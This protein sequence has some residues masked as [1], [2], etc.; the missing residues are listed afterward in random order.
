MSSTHR[1]P[2]A[3]LL[4]ALCAPAA[5]ADT[6]TA[7]GDHPGEGGTPFT[8]LAQ[9]P[10]ANLFTGAL[11]TGVPI[12]VP[13]GRSGMTPQL[14]LQHVSGGGPSPFGHG[15]DLTLG[16]IER[17]SRW[18]TPRCSGGH[19]DEFVLVL[20]SGAAELVR[21]TPSSRYY[22]PRV[23]QAWVRA[24]RI[25]A[26]N[27]WQVVDR[28]GR[29]YSFGDVDAAR[30]GNSDPLTFLKQEADGSCRLTSV[31]ALT[32]VADPNGNAIDIAWSKI[33]N[34][35]YPATVRW[36][37]N[38]A[39]G[40]SHF[41][42]VRFLPEWRP[43]T[44]R[45]ASA[46]LGVSARLAWRIYGIDVETDLPSAGTI[47]RSYALQYRDGDGSGADGY[48]SMLAAVGVT[49]RPTQH[50]VYTP[51]VTGHDAISQPFA[52]PAIAYERLRETNDS[53]E[54]SQSVLDMNGDG[55][56]DLVRSN[57]A[58]AASWAVF[59]GR[60]G[61]DGSF[62]FD[63][64][65][66]AWQAP[67]NWTHLR[68]VD[69]ASGACN[70]NGWQC[71]RL[72][73]F[74]LTGDGIPDFVD[75][76]SASS[77]TVY[78]G[79]G[80]PQWGFGPGIAWP[81]PNLRYVRRS[82]FGD[83][84]QDVVDVN[85][86]GLADLVRSGAP[87]QTAPFQ[88]QVYL[89]TGSGFATTALPRFPA[90][91]GTL[92][93][94]VAG[95]IGHELVDFNGDGLP[96]LVRSG[97]AGGFL[98]D[99]RCQP[100]S[101]ALTSCLEV[102]LNRGDGF[103]ELEAPIPVPMSN[104]VQTATDDEEVYQDLFDVNGDGLP[105]WLY[106][107]YDFTLGNFQPEW[108]VL[109]NLG[110]TLEPVTYVP[111]TVSPLY[112]EAIPPRVWPGGAGFFRRSSDGQSVVDLVD[113]NGDGLLDQL[114]TGGPTWFV[115]LHAAAEH[116]NLLGLLENGLGGTTTVVYR[117][118]TAFDNSGGDAQPDLPFIQ[119]V[120]AR[121]RQ[122][123]GLCTPPASADPFVAGPGPNANPCIDAGHE[124]IA[125]YDYEDGRFDAATR[126]F[127]GF[128]RVARSLHEG[129][130]A[131]A[132]L[133]VSVFA[134]DALVKGRVLSVDTYAGDTA[135]VRNETNLWGTRDAGNGRSQ[136]WLAEQR[137]ATLDGG[138]ASVPLYVTT[139][140]DAPDEY[141]NITHARREGLFGA[142]RVD[143][144]TTYA[145]PQSG[146]LVYD[147]PSGVRVD[148]ASGTLQEEWLYYDGG[149]TNGLAFGKIVQGNLKRRVQRLDAAVANG[150]TTRME[151]DAVGNLTRATDAN[152]RVT[153][154]TYDS[155][156]L[157]PATVT[158]PLG[159]VTTT[160]FDLRVGQP[161]QVTD[162][163]GATTSYA[164]DSAGRR[165]CEAR[166]Y[167]SLATC[168]R[169]TVYHFA[170][171]AG[172]LSWVEH[173]VRQDN[174]PPLWVRQYFDG[175]GRARYSDTLR[176]VDGAPTMVRGN[177]VEYDAA[178]RVA[179][180]RQPH[181][182]GSAA[183]GVTSFDY[184]LNGG[185]A[186]DPLG[187]IHLTTAPDHT[188]R[189]SIYAGPTTSSWDE[190]NQQS[191]TVV[192]GVGRVVER[193]SY[194]DGSVAMR[195]QQS[196]DGLGRL[197]DVRQNGTLLKSFS[198]DALGRKTRM[199]DLD[200]GTWRY[201]YDAV[202]NLLW[203]DDPRAGHHVELCYDAINR[204]TRRCSYPSDFT[205]SAACSAACTDPD[206]VLIQY[207]AASVPFGRGRRTRV[208]DG[209]GTAEVLAYD[210]RGRTLATRRSIELDGV[211]RAARF[212]YAYDTNDRVTAVTYPDGEVV[213]T[214]YDDAGQPIALYNT[215]GT[216]YVTDARYDLRG[217]P[218]RLDH[219]N[220]LSDQRT[221]GGAATQYRLQALRSLGP[222]GT[223]L[224]LTFPAYT[225]RGLL[226]RIAD[227]RN[228]S[229]PLSDTV[230]YDYDALGRLRSADSAHNPLDRSFEY[231]AMGNLARN[232]DVA[233][234]Y[235]NP[236]RPHQVTHVAAP[237]GAATVA[238]DEN[239]N[240]LG[241]PGQ[242]YT[243]DTADQLARVDVG[244]QTVRYLH[245]A[246]G[247]LVGKLVD[248]SP[249]QTA[250]YYDPRLEV[251][252]TRQTKW[253]FL[254]ERRIASMTNGY[255]SWQTAARDP[256][257]TVWLAAAPMSRPALIL[258][259]GG[260]ARWV[261]AALLLGLTT[262]T[263]A[264]RGPR[265]AAGGRRVRRGH[266]VGVALLGAVG[267]LPWPLAVGPAPAWAGGGGG[268]GTSSLP[269]Y[270]FHLDHLGSIQA[271]SDANGYLF[272]Q[273]RYQPF[274]GVSGRFNGSGQPY[275]GSSM[276]APRYFTGYLTDPLAGL[277][278]AGARVYDPELGSFLSHDPGSQ[279][280]S[281]YSYG[282]GDP[283]NW[284][285]PNGEFFFFFLAALFVSAF[286]SAAVSTVIAAAQGLP[287]S[288]VGRAAIGGAIAGAIGVGI[289]V[290]A[291]A[292]SIG[293]AALAGTL[294]QNVTLQQVG[295]ALTGV[296]WRSAYS[297]TLANAAGQTA[298]AVGAPQPVALL[299]SVAA[300]FLSSVQFD[301]AF[302]N[303][304][305]AVA[306][307]VSQRSGGM[308]STTA[309]HTDITSMAAA[310]AGFSDAEA[311]QILAGSL[312]E[313]LNLWGN[314]DHFDFLSQQ[315]A[316]A[317]SRAAML[318]ADPT[319][320]LGA[321]RMFQYTGAALHHVQD[322]YAL[323]HVVP[324]TSAFGGPLG[325]PARFLI[326]N[327]A[328]GEVTFRQASY[329]ASLQLLRDVRAAS[330][331]AG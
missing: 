239:G 80:V 281:P 12:E 138:A 103:G 192:D 266:A 321:Q 39:A 30:L 274:G 226:Q 223:A 275:V 65:P 9:V 172:E 111:S 284:T 324:G 329:D 66:T 149:T 72:D 287:L 331:A 292:T 1:L 273:V 90:P 228:P 123:D 256:G 271:V 88:W 153:V 199:S 181:V 10:E 11:S 8:G 247:V 165:V 166:P 92:V 86:D 76:S 238:H 197:L 159:H 102:Y 246:D 56:L 139:I 75:A 206:P 306:R 231:D 283:V 89:N 230:T 180:I 24:E 224:D 74:D 237:G 61:G 134:Q 117:P 55:L 140:S 83:T 268:G 196:Y 317:N 315:A 250:R 120:V 325:A 270:H 168:S 109:L 77:W 322:P 208:E 276:E 182:A 94:H 298:T 116:P 93:D 155:V 148:D 221:Y 60:V 15:W 173:A 191:D 17:S 48:Q 210:A 282:G 215:A 78:P 201:G 106:R 151:Y 175:L 69:V 220:G 195:V 218:L 244:G 299:A 323:G 14:T 122:N 297:T 95:G 278:H 40:I 25:D 19:T 162:P 178:G 141:G 269:I 132:G 309:T 302:A 79:R 113:V 245:D 73:T 203:Q 301:Q 234:T 280:T 189:R 170:A 176:V 144:T 307:D 101:T 38:P 124:L 108:R 114:T 43:P 31:W 236:S 49:G 99:P 68:N 290:L 330:G 254:G 57:D 169:S 129:S 286:A 300:G 288:A 32:R 105:D 163:N 104:A 67:G 5:R 262:L 87:G 248:G 320:G 316:G 202:G 205:T 219:A 85:G 243:Y 115:R 161:S 251:V 293:A 198:Y 217:R 232:G 152:G 258:A 143:T 310:D 100:S 216:F 84:Y 212:D 326:H 53:L 127:R 45:I 107:R 186:R 157:H 98:Y 82:Y 164:Y 35:L 13:P 188:T 305:G 179:L 20:P 263:F 272:E 190:E 59:W 291:T 137:I 44:D 311:Q 233:L 97:S 146:S 193:R 121:T 213:R 183:D 327:L 264:W 242:L 308:C 135:L 18:G 41:Y 255:L 319:N 214:E 2:L 64:A 174:H 46:R 52:K 227:Q 328:G 130:A 33:F 26:E 312:A 160:A 296:A 36:G 51:S 142:N 222:R 91:V 229:G 200:S 211:A 21:E 136:I 3:V 204:P 62:G 154:T 133:T 131:P 156:L 187:R 16:R 158:N 4:V 58:P 194:A 314:E 318:A 128:R 241:K 261:A 47:I 184:R 22:R 209:A 240:R 50:F 177:E 167:D 171:A 235:G 119:W 6:G 34:T 277:A 71:T 42:T 295:V 294:A 150:P 23:E 265:P 96:D 304:V 225:A 289:G 285:D 112:S 54:V 257:A 126:E 125:T 147:K 110:G 313:D 27:R 260:A 145:K 63:S 185:T 37:G 249:T 7:L 303:H 279:F 252:G 28:S 29:I 118:S 207:D 267:M 253:Y 81:A 259:I 70:G